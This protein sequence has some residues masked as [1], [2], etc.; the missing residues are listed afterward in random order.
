MVIST[1]FVLICSILSGFISASVK[2]IYF[3]AGNC[4]LDVFGIREV[5]L[6]YKLWKQASILSIYLQ[7][8]TKLDTKNLRGAK[9]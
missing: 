8:A 6:M 9:F 1:N 2:T 4:V 5:F 3:I 7:L